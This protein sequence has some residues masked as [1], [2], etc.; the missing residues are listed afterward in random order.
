MRYPEAAALAAGALVLGA[1]AALER[2]SAD[3]AGVF[4][5]GSVALAGFALVAILRGEVRASRAPAPPTPP[6]TSGVRAWLQSG[7]I[8]REEIVLLLDRLE[9]E[10]LHPDLP[11]STVRELDRLRYLP[12]PE[13]RKYVARRLDDI[14]GGP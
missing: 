8:G 7:P 5:A 1:I 12:A 2:R 14:E 13:F 4:A 6:E 10:S 11:S 3:A 9:R